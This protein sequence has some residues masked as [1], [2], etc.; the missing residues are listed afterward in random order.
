M[1]KSQGLALVLVLWVI[2][3]LTIMASS[4]ALTVQRESVVITGI[5]ENAEASALAEAGINYAI[6]KLLNKDKEQ[7]WNAFNSLYEIY[8]QDKKIR[9]LIA[10]ESGKIAINYA[11]KEQLQQLFN[12][13]SD[14]ELLVDS[15]SDAILDW[16][17]RNDL[18]RL[19]GA[20]K[21]QYAEDDLEYQPRN[22]PF[23]SLEEL[24]MVKGMTAEI[25]QQLKDLVS[26]Y[27][28]KAKINPQTAS[29]LVLLTLPD[30]TE[31]LVDEY[32]KQRVENE[33]NSEK[34]SLPEWYAGGAGKSNVYMIVAEVMIDKDITQ[35]TMAMIRK[36]KSKKSNKPY[37]VLQWNNNHGQA[38]L[39]LS[40]N[41]DNVINQDD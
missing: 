37:E 36:K 6:I 2:S 28:K 7:Q 15:L 18:H 8:F 20:E 33:R 13:L 1:E 30:A 38:S 31:E 41:D 10:E 25:Y 11:K 40:N 35:Q 24:Q 9:I 27:T 3:L 26:I 22:A 12:S 23:A 17:D 39:F 32:I 19:N 21:E 4:F 34:I 5:K 14:D 16:V 29:R